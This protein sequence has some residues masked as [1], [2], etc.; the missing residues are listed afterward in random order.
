MK[1]QSIFECL[2]WYI[3]YMD[4]GQVLN[5]VNDRLALAGI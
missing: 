4:L 3:E 5:L 2:Y 1:V